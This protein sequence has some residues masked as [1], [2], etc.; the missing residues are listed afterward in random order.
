MLKNLSLI[1]MAAL[2]L[3]IMWWIFGNLTTGSIV[4]AV[5]M[6]KAFSV[7]AMLVVLF[8]GYRFI[9]RLLTP[10]EGD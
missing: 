9:R 6:F 7:I 5:I 1:A 4:L 2:L 10:S 8:I 3:M